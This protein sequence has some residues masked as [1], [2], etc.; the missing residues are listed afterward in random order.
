MSRREKKTKKKKEV[1]YE[2]VLKQID[3][4]VAGFSVIF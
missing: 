4:V 2:V 3:Q 1:V